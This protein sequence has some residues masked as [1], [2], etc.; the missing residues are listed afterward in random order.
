MRFFAI[1]AF[2]FFLFHL[3]STSI[4]ACSCSPPP[5]PCFAFWQ[6]D[7]VFIGKVTKVESRQEATYP[8]VEVEVEENFRGMNY[9]KAFTHNHGTSCSWDFEKGDK[10]L[11]YADLDKNDNSIFGT[12]FCTRTKVY[13]E[14]LEDLEF[15]KSLRNPTPNYW[16]WGTITRG[17]GYNGSLEGVR[18][19]IVG[20]GKKPS[21]ISDKDGNLKI[22]L[23]KAGIY[24]VRVYPPKGTT[25]D[26]TT[27]INSL[28]REIQIKILKNYDIKKKNA[29]I[30]YE[31]EVKANQCGWFNLPL[32]IL[33]K[34]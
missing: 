3:S 10:I 20:N 25:I 23:S 22:S 19:E 32:T 34:E 2:L 16:V 11:F 7:A 31:I 8:K 12:N 13:D 28:Y 21:A 33:E 26:H 30:D 4:I 6:S 15:F 29:F 9:K 14:N 17:Y 18:A 27:L 5:P 1:F 24:K